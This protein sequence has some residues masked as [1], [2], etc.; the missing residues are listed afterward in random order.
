MAKVS[1]KESEYRRLVR[2]DLGLGNLAAFVY[3]VTCAR[4]RG[5]GLSKHG[6]ELIRERCEQV[7]ADEDYEEEGGA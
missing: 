2:R 7:L 6:A 4:T 1:I 5:G 3:G